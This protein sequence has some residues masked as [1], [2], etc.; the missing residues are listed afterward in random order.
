MA[1]VRVL[2]VQRRHGRRVP[3]VGVE[4]MGAYSVLLNNQDAVSFGLSMKGTNFFDGT[5]LEFTNREMKRC[6]KP[7]NPLLGWISTRV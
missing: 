3:S 7:V 5:E 6:S 1:L 2:S 4:L